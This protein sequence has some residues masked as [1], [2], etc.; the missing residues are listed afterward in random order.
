MKVTAVQ[1]VNDLVAIGA[2]NV[3]L[4]QG[5]RIPQDISVIGFGNIL[6]SE[7]FRVPLT[8]L[9]QPKHRMGDAAID[10]MLQLL[11]GKI[12]E[13]RRLP[14]DLVI[15]ASTAIPHITQR[16]GKSFVQPAE[17]LMKI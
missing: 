3:L 9:R 11:A 5:L 2:A 4:N 17:P 8:T 16:H 6:A 7:Y 14:A 12:P 13:S 1:A 10:C 15:R